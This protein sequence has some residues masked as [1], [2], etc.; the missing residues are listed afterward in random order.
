MHRK[1]R[2]KGVCQI[3]ARGW[4]WMK[5]CICAEGLQTWCCTSNQRG[6]RAEAVAQATQ[7]D[8]DVILVVGYNYD[9]KAGRKIQVV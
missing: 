9:E 7:A 8:I 5:E 4:S 2:G 6:S 3:V 1:S